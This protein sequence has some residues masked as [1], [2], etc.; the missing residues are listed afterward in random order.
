M[1]NATH[2]DGCIIIPINK[3]WIRVTALT[4]VLMLEV[5]HAPLVGPQGY[6]PLC[7]G[8]DKADFG[9]STV[10]QTTIGEKT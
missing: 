7:S 2:F 8:Q 9:E 10:G 4:S 1:I 5:L 3:T 6:K